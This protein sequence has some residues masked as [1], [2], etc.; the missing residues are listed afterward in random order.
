MLTF[1]I[2]NSDKTVQ[3]QTCAAGECMAGE[4]INANRISG[5]YQLLKNMPDDA[6]QKLQSVIN[7]ACHVY[8]GK[9]A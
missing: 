7:Y 4:I 5:K 2:E 6:A 9:V 8:C 3:I 1:N